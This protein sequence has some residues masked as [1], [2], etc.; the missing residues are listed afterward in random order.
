MKIGY[1]RVSTGDQ[2]IDLQIDALKAAGCEK[3]FAEHV[4]GST[5][6]QRAQL[7]AAMDFIRDG[8][9]LVVTRLDRLARS[10]ADILQIVTELKAKGV[11]FICTEQAIDTTSATGKLQMHML[12]A[13]A[14][15]ERSILLERQREGIAKAKA[16]GKFKGRKRS[17]DRAL[18]VQRLANGDRP[19][20][21][22]R[23]LGIDRTSVYRIA[24]EAKAAQR[25]A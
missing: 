2:D 4:S 24:R 5:R 21:I 14:E 15:F 19:T 8:D 1:A 22:A 11:E 23:D 9:V 25:V 16:A 17:I 18:V 3:I 12:A 10:I 13:V 6:A 7:A 20:A